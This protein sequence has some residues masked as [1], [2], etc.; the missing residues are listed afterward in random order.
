MKICL[1]GVPGTVVGKHPLKDPRLD[2]AHKLV[3]ADKKTYAAVDV[4]G[5]DGLAECDAIVATDSSALELVLQDLEFVETRLGRDATDAEKLVLE[6]MKTDL[7]A[8]RCLSACAYTAADW[9]AVNA[10][11]LI[12]RKPVVIATAEEVNQPDPLLVRAVAA[13]GWISFLTVGG[14]E[15]RAW[16]IRQGATAWEA[17][18]AIHTDIHKGFIRAEIIGWADFV[19]AGGE[20]QAKRAGKLRLETKQYVM[21]DYDLVNFRFNKTG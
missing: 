10:S 15:N 20:T 16:L 21:Q 18:G 7:E 2:T 9:E 4:T 11:G 5:D 6:R 12:T 19:T 13:T 1:Y 14:K 17:G 8:G 3:A